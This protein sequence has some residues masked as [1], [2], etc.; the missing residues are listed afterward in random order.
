MKKTI[1]K[2]PL[3]VADFQEIQMPACAEVL[4]VQVQYG[5]PC[6][7]AIVSPE[8]PKE[9]RTFATYGTGHE[10]PDATELKQTFIGTY[11]LPGLVYHVFETDIP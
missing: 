3:D 8:A 6:M 9:T 7:W 11:Q 5:T 4:S 10:F 2:F 1:W